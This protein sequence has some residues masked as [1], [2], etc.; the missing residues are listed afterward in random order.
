[1][2]RKRLPALTS[3]AEVLSSATN[4][5]K[6]KHAKMAEKL[7]GL[8][9]Q[10]F[11][12]TRYEVPNGEGTVSIQTADGIPV[13]GLVVNY[14]NLG[15]KIRLTSN[16]SFL[17]IV[18]QRL[19]RV[20]I[21][22]AGTTVYESFATIAWVS[23]ESRELGL[24]LNGIGLPLASVE[25]A[26]S[27][28]NIKIDPKN[29]P[30]VSDEFKILCSDFSVF[31]AQLK[32]E[33]EAKEAE[34]K[35]YSRCNMELSKLDKSAIDNFIAAYSK[36]FQDIFYEFSEVTSKIRS[37][38]EE[39]FKQ[40]FRF[41]FHPDFMQSPFIERSYSKPLDYAG[42][43]GLMKMLYEYEDLG[44]TL[45]HRFLHRIVCDEPAAKA[46]K[47]RVE[48]LAD[49]ISETW[50]SGDL[51]ISSIAC[52]PCRELELF[53]KRERRLNDKISI[54]C[55]DSEGRALEHAR[56]RLRVVS[57]VRNHTELAFL[58]ENAV[59]GMVKEKASYQMA[60]DSDIIISAGLFD[61]LSDSVAHKTISAIFKA[62]KPGGTM[63]IGNV[64]SNNPSKFSMAY[65][66]EWTLI[67][68]NEEELKSLVS[69]GVYEMSSSVKV[70]SEPLNINLFLTIKKKL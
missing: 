39:S 11:R 47:N 26:L 40:Y 69:S 4:I 44:P 16:D 10:E 1:M 62:L 45:F 32:L 53:L 13:E 43:Y 29:L 18:S 22:F 23:P 2:F 64:S 58:C 68:R 37:G 6:T 46:N 66:S 63:I 52:G 17:P 60:K 21:I 14:S 70:I 24:M 48:L 3:L 65:L 25:S 9:M 20:R 28:A 57:D 35:T 34:L 59:L 67:E 51:K 36:D 61:Y 31:L 30:S 33:M 54:C 49:L 7:W 42:D 5:S 8:K 12:E 27:R 41:L 19:R 55:I 15:V 38:E 50:E 56:S